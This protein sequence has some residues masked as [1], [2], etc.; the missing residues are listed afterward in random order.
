MS[1]CVAK[2]RFSLS[3]ALVVAGLL[4]AAAP[5]H[6]EDAKRDDAAK[7]VFLTRLFAGPVSKPK[8][9]ACFVRV[10]DADHL[11][12]HKLQKVGAMKLL[13]TAEKPAEKSEDGDKMSYGFQL[14]L[15]FRNRSAAFESAGYCS[16]SDLTED[17]NPGGEAHFGC[18]VDCD[19]GGIRVALKNDDKS[20]IVSLERVRI[21]RS[22]T[23]SDPETADGLVAGADDK[24]FRLDRAPLSECA[25][26]ISDKKERAAMLRMT[27]SN[28]SKK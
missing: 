14:G 2:G 7:E 24:E 9:Y 27:V 17:G 6:A 25:P 13:V 12:R 22:G 1:K 11:V 16:N 21:W 5:S 20:A 23:D 10:Y 3:L 4:A 15:K 28:V 18:G 26:L 19:G 8:N